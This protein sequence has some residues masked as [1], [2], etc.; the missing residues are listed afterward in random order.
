MKLKGKIAFITGGASGLGAATARYFAAQGAK[1]AVLDL[2]KD[3][4]NA[5]AQEIGGVAVAADVCDPAAVDGAIE[6]A[7]ETL[8]NAPQVVVNCAGVAFGARVVARD[9]GMARR[10]TTDEGAE[11]DDVSLALLSAGEGQPAG[12][13]VRAVSSLTERGAVTAISGST[14]W[15]ALPAKLC[16]MA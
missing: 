11:T 6:T 7:C 14:A 9:G 1:V 4:V 8:G 10:L 3:A 15:P 16:S 12:L 5:V 2:N 13:R